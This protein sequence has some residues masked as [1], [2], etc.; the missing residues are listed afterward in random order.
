MKL[1]HYWPARRPITASRTTIYA[2]LIPT[3]NSD[4]E[5]EEAAAFVARLAPMRRRPGRS[6]SRANG[7]ERCM[8]GGRPR[9]WTC[10]LVAAQRGCESHV[11]DNK[12]VAHLIELCTLVYPKMFGPKLADD[13]E[14]W[15]RVVL[16][17]MQEDGDRA[18]RRRYR[19]RLVG[20]AGPRVRR[21]LV[22]EDGLRRS[23]PGTAGPTD[24]LPGPGGRRAPH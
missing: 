19:R 8:A 20:G 22:P 24:R 12:P 3:P 9:C 1:V 15:T 23:Q 18:C 11:L 4:D 5:R 21:G 13:F 6:A 7:S 16:D 10:S 2:A 14:H 17:R